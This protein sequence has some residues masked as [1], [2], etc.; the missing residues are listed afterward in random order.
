MDRAEREIVTVS[1]HTSRRAGDEPLRQ[2]DSV[3]A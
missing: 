2:L 1:F 3:G